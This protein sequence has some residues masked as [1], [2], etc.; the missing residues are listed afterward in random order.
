V[1]VTTLLLTP[2]GLRSARELQKVGLLLSF[3]Y[4]I[5]PGFP[6]PI[7]ETPKVSSTNPPVLRGR[8]QENF[9]SDAYHVATCG[10][11]IA[12]GL[13]GVGSAQ[14]PSEYISDGSVSTEAK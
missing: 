2:F 8:T 9:G 10:A 7:P 4:L 14:S 13:G 1:V 5:Y 6:E 11:S 12:T 3:L